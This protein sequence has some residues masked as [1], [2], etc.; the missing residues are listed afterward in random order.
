M[1]PLTRHCVRCGSQESSRGEHRAHHLLIGDARRVCGLV[2]EITLGTT[3][4]GPRLESGHCP[5]GLQSLH[6]MGTRSAQ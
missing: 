1:S 2:R 6:Q 5:N 4:V 3:Q